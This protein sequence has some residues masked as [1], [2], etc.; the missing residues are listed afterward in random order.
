MLPKANRIVEVRRALIL[1]RDFGVCNSVEDATSSASA[2]SNVFDMDEFERIYREQVD[3]VFRFVLLRVGR[4][5]IAEDITSEV[6]LTLHR[7]WSQIDISQL[8]SWLFTVA[9]NA[10]VD[11][12]RRRAVEQR[13][14]AVRQQEPPPITAAPP[15][16][17]LFQSDALKPAHRI[18]LVLR[19]AY[20]MTL[21]EIST[22]TGFS[23]NQVKS[24]LQYAKHLLR[25]QLERAK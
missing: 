5:D 23:D 16:I 24:Y 19:Y 25:T 1:V 7:N 22:Y 3:A 12:W 18:C 20:G 2:F 6:F 10:T 15:D 17:P 14:A 4:R 13:Y 8:P 21:N 11:Y 9:R